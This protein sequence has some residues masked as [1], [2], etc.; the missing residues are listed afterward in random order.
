MFRRIFSDKNLPKLNFIIG[1]TALTFQISILY[2]WHNQI[3]IQINNMK[4]YFDNEIKIIKSEKKNEKGE[5]G[6]KSD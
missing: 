6:K 5:K 3:S 4:N 1:L 2:P